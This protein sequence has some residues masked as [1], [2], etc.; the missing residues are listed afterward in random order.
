MAPNCWMVRAGSGGLVA[1]D[2]VEKGLVGIGWG[3]IGPLDEFDKKSAIESAIREEYPDW[4]TGRHRSSSS[5][6][7]RFRLG[8]SVGD[9]VVTYDSS[10]RIYH[11]GTVESDYLHRPDLLP[12]YPNVRKVAWVG[13]VERD[14]LSV[15][16]RNT[17]GSTLTLFRL[18]ESAAEEIERALAGQ[19]ATP[20]HD[21]EDADKD[22]NTILADSKSRAIEFIKDR[23]N[24]LDANEM[25]QLVAGLLRA[26]GYKTRVSPTGADRGIDVMASPDGFGFE[27]PRIVVEVK[28]RSSTAMGAQELR[29][30]LGGR[31]DNDKGL[32]VS[33]GGFTKDAR[34]E[35]DRAKI[36][37]MLMDLD[38]LVSAL[39]EYY[40]NADAKTRTL[41]PLEKTY[42]PAWAD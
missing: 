12:E 35:A 34:Y 6:L 7:Q 36:P 37:L 29:T 30:F 16:T 20:E 23:V 17:L 15:A 9:R 38:E 41:L 25:E 28:H 22:E 14:R 21:E 19:V 2:F 42:W 39:L 32:Y 3:D 33:T 18:S 1:D 27:S 8:L 10:R 26:M 11:V 13:V 24:R 5:Q 4:P 31:H 40:E